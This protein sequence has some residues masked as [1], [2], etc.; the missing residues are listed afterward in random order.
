MPETPTAPAPVAEP[1]T[2]AAV[3]PAPVAEPAT[4][5]PDVETQLAGL[6]S[7]ELDALMDSMDEGKR[8]DGDPPE[9]AAVEPAKV[10]PAPQ[11][12]AVAPTEDDEDG[13]GQLPKNFRFHTED[14]TMSRFLKLLKSTPGVD[15][16]TLWKNAGGKSTL[17]EQAQAAALETG[18]PTAAAKEA[19][20]QLSAEAIAA[21]LAT[22]K[23]E[24][25]AARKTFEY[26]K[27]DKAQDE[28]DDLREQL[29]DAKLAAREKV[30]E[31]ASF[32]SDLG[33]VQTSMVQEYPDLLNEKSPLYAEMSRENAFAQ[34]YEP[35]LFTNPQFARTLL[36]RVKTRRPELFGK[37]VA[38]A[39]A[40]V[41]VPAV[42]ATPVGSVVPGQ[43][44]SQQ[45]TMTPQAAM[46]EIEKLSEAELNALIE[47]LPTERRKR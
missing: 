4:S 40:A 25:D 11:A 5:T 34:V 8:P 47:A 2:P 28:I 21:R 36:D 31:A 44:G 17:F 22:L 15:P 26:D 18:T 37:P 24:R 16:A 7:E 45:V 14:A 9:P 12:A 35:G 27:A 46:G 32:E 43:A 29:T 41:P 6:S 3:T 19:P 39:A 38:A 33:R 42:A 10:T 1:A 20:P 13:E 23:T 30:R